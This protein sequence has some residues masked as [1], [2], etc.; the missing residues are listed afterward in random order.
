MNAS[1][2]FP[3]FISCIPFGLINNNPFDNFSLINKITS[4]IIIIHSKSDRTI[5]Y[6]HAL[7]LQT[8]ANPETSLLTTNYKHAISFDRDYPEYKQALYKKLPNWFYKK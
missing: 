8:Q 4:P 3:L 2:R 5:A 6:Q 7:D 1:A